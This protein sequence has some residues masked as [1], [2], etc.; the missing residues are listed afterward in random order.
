MIKKPISNNTPVTGIGTSFDA[1]KIITMDMG[2]FPPSKPFR[3]FVSII[4]IQ[5]DNISSAT[6]CT[7]RICSDTTGNECLVTDT[8]SNIFNGIT[9]ATTGT[10]EIDVAGFLGLVDTDQFYFFLKFNNG[11]ADCRYIEL[12]WAD[13]G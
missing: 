1:S 9:T 13:K 7:M 10:A 4:R 12:N 5:L 2:M 6:T 3:G 11:S 8:T